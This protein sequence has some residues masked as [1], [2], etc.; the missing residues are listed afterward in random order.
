MPTIHRIGN[1]EIRI[2]FNDTKK[3][4]DPHFHADSPDSDLVVSIRTLKVI[5]R[6]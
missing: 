2:N 5:G 3:H 6:T 4:K 1:V